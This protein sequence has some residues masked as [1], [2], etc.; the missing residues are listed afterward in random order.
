[1]RFVWLLLDLEPGALPRW[2]QDLG[3]LTKKDR[4]RYKSNKDLHEVDLDID[5]NPFKAEMWKFAFCMT[6]IGF[7]ARSPSKMKPRS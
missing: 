5:S 6:V 7:E 4:E 2:N 3:S 1:M